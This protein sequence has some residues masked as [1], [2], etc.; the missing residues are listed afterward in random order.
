MEP[1]KMPGTEPPHPG[2]TG[3]QAQVFRGSRRRI[4]KAAAGLRRQQ[5]QNV[6]GS[7]HRTAEAAGAYGEWRQEA[8][9]D[10]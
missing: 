9:T 2:K 8:R 1:Q 7:R 3:Q 10:E 4:L 5:A 6:R